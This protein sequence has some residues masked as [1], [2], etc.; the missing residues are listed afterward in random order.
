MPMPDS[1]IVRTAY[2][3][4]STDAEIRT[5][6]SSGGV[7]SSIVKFCFDN[8]II[9]HV[10][11]F[12]YDQ[13]TLR[14]TPYFANSFSDYNICG[15]IY[16]EMNMWDFYKRHFTPHELGKGCTLF[17]CL[18]CQTKAIRSI[19]KK[20]GMDVILVGLACSSQQSIDATHYLLDCIGLERQ[21]VLHLQYRGNGWPSGI[22][23]AT[24]S[25]GNVFVPNNGSIWTTI[26]HSRLFI[27]RRC[28]HC[29][30][31]LNET[32][33]IT[34][35]DP[36]LKEYRDKEKIGKSLVFANTERGIQL[37]A[38]ASK[39]GY[40]NLDPID[41]IQ[42]RSSQN[43]TIQRKQKYSEHPVL[44]RVLSNLCHN[45]VYRYFA[46]SCKR[47]FRLHC[48]L[49]NVIEQQMMKGGGLR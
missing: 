4:Y 14:Y 7:G 43:L 21:D 9:T 12:A 40:V 13:N 17:F 44:C 35:A 1:E 15:S 6:A 32:A 8:Q 30:D 31:T 23:I 45:N 5:R 2:V 16:Q 19:A 47:G 42:A 41:I 48:R 11:S 39:A 25:H 18:P 22:Q 26:F 29:R 24:K 37:L 10:L 33:D 20:H 49:K 36:W 3:G 46:T 28:F 38:N 34:L 27:P